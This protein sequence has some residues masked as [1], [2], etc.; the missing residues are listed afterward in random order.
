M[1]ETEGKI[2]ITSNENETLLSIFNVVDADKGEYECVIR[3][4]YGQH[5][6]KVQ[7]RV[8]GVNLV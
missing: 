6:E 3:T 7:L 5:S 1:V 2:K 8:K 4:Q